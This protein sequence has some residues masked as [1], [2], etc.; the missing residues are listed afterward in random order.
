MKDDCLWEIYK[1]ETKISS[2]RRIIRNWIVFTH[3]WN[4]QTALCAYK[5]SC[6]SNNNTTGQSTVSKRASTSNKLIIISKRE[7]T[8]RRKNVDGKNIIQEL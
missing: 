1:K 3:P 7:R 2:S 8:D 5:Q 6:R 4:L